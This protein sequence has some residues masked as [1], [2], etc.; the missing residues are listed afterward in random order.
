MTWQDSLRQLDAR[1]ADGEIGAAD[2]RKARDE[3]LAEASSGNQSVG[4]ETPKGELWMSTNPAAPPAQPA[5][6]DSETTQVVKTDDGATQVVTPDDG[7][8]QVVT[9][10]DGATRTVTPDEA[11]QVVTPDDEATQVVK[12]EMLTS[13]PPGPRIQQ[14]RPPQFGP[15]VPPIQYPRAAPIQGQEVFAEARSSGAGTALKILV[16]LLILALVG[17]AVWWFALRDDSTP[18]VQNED[19]PASSQQPSASQ[20]PSVADVAEKVPA[21]PGEAKPES[22]T[23]TAAE[24]QEQKLLTPAYAKLLTD[25]GVD[26]IVYRKSAGDGFG[27]LL[28]AAPIEPSGGAVDTATATSDNLRQA[29]FETA[30]PAESLGVPVVTRTDQFFRTFVAMY[31]SED[32]WVQLNVS[33]PPDGDAAALRTEFEKV[34]R[35]VTKELP[36]A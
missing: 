13:A 27:Y 24:A 22:G 3:I 29:G 15:P 20:V 34:L 32:I 5:Q 23:L 7:A 14:Q 30:D 33:G 12:A 25:N 35:S 9:P 10:D 21:L 19:P 2:Y 28:V 16:P 1:L 31:A 11:T 17:V 18:A 4:G 8:T 26:D 6:V 36:A